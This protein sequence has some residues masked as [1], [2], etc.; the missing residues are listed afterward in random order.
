MTTTSST[1][2]QRQESSI[3]RP[4]RDNLHARMTNELSE[5]DLQTLELQTLKTEDLDKQSGRKR[6]SYSIRPISANHVVRWI[7]ENNL[8]LEELMAG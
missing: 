3:H 4:H 1:G 5:S 7:S 8:T 2:G 6:N